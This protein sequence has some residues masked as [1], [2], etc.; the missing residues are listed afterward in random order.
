MV[1][2]G[3]LGCL[4]LF[5]SLDPLLQGVQTLVDGGAARA[6][7]HKAFDLAGVSVHLTAG[8][9]RGPDQHPTGKHHDEQEQ[10]HST[11]RRR[12][13]RPHEALGPGLGDVHSGLLLGL[14]IL[15]L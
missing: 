13:E 6:L 15:A 10:G 5:E 8:R 14:A 9:P 11:I 12:W 1:P 7:G 4:P 3:L 2:H